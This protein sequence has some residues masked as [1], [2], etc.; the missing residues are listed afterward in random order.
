[1]I[2]VTDRVSGIVSIDP[3]TGI[4]TLLVPSSA[5]GG[6]TARGICLADDH[7]VAVTTTGSGIGA[8]LTVDLRTRELTVI[9]EG[10]LL[11]NPACVA[12]GPGG[13][14]Y[15]GDQSAN[16]APNGSGSIVRVERSGAQSL[17][18]NGELF[19]GPFD[20]AIASDGWVWTAQWGWTSRRGGGFRR[21][22]LS[23]G[24]TEYVQSDR[25]QGVA[26]TP[27]GEVYL[28]DCTSISLDCYPESRFVHRF[29]AGTRSGLPAGAMAVVPAATTP[30]RRSTWGS[31]KTL[32]R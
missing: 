28:G 17:F 27:D 15:V 24:H 4:Q 31:L 11:E 19:Q 2:H 32:Y 13:T 3:G 22:R 8:V 9:S 25:S 30:V 29:V 12:A 23:D 26:A 1:M 5:L 16:S 21:T 20:I 10:G 18:A 7:T 14:L 6:R